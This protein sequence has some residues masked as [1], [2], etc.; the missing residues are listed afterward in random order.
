M[1]GSDASVRRRETLTVDV[2][3]VLVGSAQSSG[4]RAPQ[5]ALDPRRA[6]DR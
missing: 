5:S 6:H 4:G 2:G 3:G 1:D